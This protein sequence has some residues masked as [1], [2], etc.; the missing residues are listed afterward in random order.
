MENAGEES[1]S[2]R[3]LNTYVTLACVFRSLSFEPDMGRDAAPVSSTPSK[4]T[5][6]GEDAQV[7]GRMLCVNVFVQIRSITVI[8]TATKYRKMSKYV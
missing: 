3:W 2:G 5:Q 4:K 6:W 1:E 8:L 7:G